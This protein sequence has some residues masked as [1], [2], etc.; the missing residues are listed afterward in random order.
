[1][2]DSESLMAH[3]TP[4]FY[5]PVEDRGT[6]ALAF[7]LSRS[8]ACRG[9]LDS[10]VNEWEARPNQIAEIRT[11]VVEDSQS[12]PDMVGFDGQGKKRLVVEVKFWAPMQPNQACRYFKRLDERGRGLLLFICPESRATQLWR[13][14][15]GQLDSCKCIGKL[16]PVTESEDR[17]HARIGDSNKRVMLVSWEMLLDRLAAAAQDFGVRSDIHQLRGFVQ[18][19]NA[20]AYVPLHPDMKAPD[21]IARGHPPP[22]DDSRRNWQGPEGRVVEHQETYLG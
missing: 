4:W 14:I 22:S 2:P 16:E 5:Q 13:E 3:M 11:Q 6:D 19:E 9:V 10:I 12:R 8:S 1:M 7:I 15:C 18:R 21:F 17:H 20:K